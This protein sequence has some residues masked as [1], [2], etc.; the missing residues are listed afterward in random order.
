MA[1]EGDPV[2]AAL[3]QVCDSILKG[4]VPPAETIVAIRRF[5]GCMAILTQRH[6]LAITDEGIVYQPQQGVAPTIVEDPELA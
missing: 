6:K 4:F 1:T 2:A 5:N 3:N